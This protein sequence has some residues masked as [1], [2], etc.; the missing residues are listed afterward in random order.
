MK[1]YTYPETLTSTTIPNPLPVSSP[2]LLTELQSILV[3]LQT[4]NQNQHLDIVDFMDTPVVAGTVING[5]AGA[6]TEIV[7]SL[8]ANVK[9]MEILDTTGVV[10]GLYS[11]AAASEVLIDILPLG[12]GTRI[13]EIPTGTRLSV[14]GM[15]A[16]G[17]AVGTL[18]G[19]T[20]KG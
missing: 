8:A 19:I 5:S 10:V 14:K 12:G 16:T 13:N 17:G 3:E 1:M 2:T 15:E 11:G 7:A 6:F 4:I 18:F 20:F 9:V